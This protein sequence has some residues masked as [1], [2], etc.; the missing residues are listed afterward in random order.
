MANFD[1]S[2]QQPVFKEPRVY[3][4][5][6]IFE[7]HIMETILCI[8]DSHVQNIFPEHKT[9]I[10]IPSDELFELLES[11]HLWFGPRE[12]LE[13]DP[14]FRQIIPYFLLTYQDK[15]VLY[16]RTKKGGEER[17]HNKRSLGIGGHVNTQ[18]IQYTELTQSI[19]LKRTLGQCI[20]REFNEEVQANLMEHQNITYLGVIIGRKLDVDKVHI[21]I[22][23]VLRLSSDQISPK[24]HDISQCQLC[25]FEELITQDEYLES[26]SHT[27]LTT[28]LHKQHKHEQL[29]FRY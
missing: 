23:A 29:S 20:S 5:L 19:D 24:S 6:Y 28:L 4:A 2:N 25:T 27:L 22:I 14:T 8:K 15:Y 9:F 10:Q 17:L 11:E 3:G 13:H 16:E 21:G 1:L 18:D 26:W 7:K 12:S